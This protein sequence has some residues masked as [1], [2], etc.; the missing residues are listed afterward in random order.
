LTPPP[1]VGAPNRRAVGPSPAAARSAHRRGQVGS[2]PVDSPDTRRSTLDPD[3]G[4]YGECPASLRRSPRAAGEGWARGGGRPAMGH[5]VVSAQQYLRI[6]LIA[7]QLRSRRFHGPGLRALVARASNPPA[8]AKPGSGRAGR[9]KND[10]VKLEIAARLRRETTLSTKAIAAGDIER[11]LRLHA[12]EPEI[13][14]QS[15]GETADG[16]RQAGASLCHSQG[17][18]RYG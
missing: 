7:R 15:A 9:P 4:Y 6:P 16:L 10:P 13:K 8:S 14:E 5:R 2:L 17:S 12:A 11:I 1:Q 3:R 18:F